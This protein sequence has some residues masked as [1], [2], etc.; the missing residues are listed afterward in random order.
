MVWVYGD[1]RYSG[2]ITIGVY[3]WVLYPIHLH[4]T[5]LS[6]INHCMSVRCIFLKPSLKHSLN[7]SRI[8]SDGVLELSFYDL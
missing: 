5:P 6:S 1:T 7:G 3:I 4:F 2:L 8:D